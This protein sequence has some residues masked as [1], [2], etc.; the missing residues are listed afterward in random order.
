MSI[1]AISVS[2]VSRLFFKIVEADHRHEAR[3]VNQRREHAGA[4]S[5]NECLEFTRHLNEHYLLWHTK[6]FFHTI[7]LGKVYFMDFL[8]ILK[9]REDKTIP[10][11]ASA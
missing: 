9:V 8:F 11:E 6:Q 7:L 10:E 4:I 3:V 2:G 1:P 5:V